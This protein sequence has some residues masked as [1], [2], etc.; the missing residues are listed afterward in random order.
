MRVARLD[1]I[2]VRSHSPNWRATCDD[3]GVFLVKLAPTHSHIAAVDHPLAVRDLHPGHAMS[4]DGHRVYVMNWLEGRAKRL[5]ELTSAELADLASAYETFRS[6]LGEGRIHGDFNCNNVLFADGR[7]SGIL[8]LEGVR[9]GH[10]CEDW[11]RYALTDADRLPVF[12]WR[13][14]SRL[15]ANFAWIV[16]HERFRAEDWCGAIDGFSAERFARKARRGRLSAWSRV[17]L[18]WREM[19]HRQLKAMVNGKG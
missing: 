1:R 14:R 10:P 15:K 11:V 18:L 6:A 16:A 19:F 12:S 3:G 7:V 4:L 9:E 8:D 17:S 13:R 5:D 2:A